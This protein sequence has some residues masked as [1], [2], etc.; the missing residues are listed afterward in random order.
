MKTLFTFLFFVG[1][2]ILF[3]TSMNKC[4]TS[5]ET[6]LN[7]YKKMVGEKVILKDDTLMIIDYSLVE[8][9][10]TLEDGRKISIELLNRCVLVNK[11]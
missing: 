11:H 3:S 10:F 6:E 4:S 5:F 8:S 2:I 7:K 9:N 1:V